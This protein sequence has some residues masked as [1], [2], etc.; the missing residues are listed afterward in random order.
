MIK[1]TEYSLGSIE[2]PIDNRD[3]HYSDKCELLSSEYFPET[4]DYRGQMN[5]VCNQGRLNTCVAFSASAMK[6]WQEKKDVETNNYMSSAFIYENRNNKTIDT[7]C[8]RD[9]LDILLKKGVCSDKL[10]PYSNINS[11]VI[12]KNVF[13]EASM[14][15]IKGYARIITQNELKT[16]LTNNG[17]CLIT[18]PCYNNEN[19]FWKQDDG[20]VLKGG[21]CVLIVGYNRYGYILRNSWGIY[22]GE[23]GHT[24]Y[25]YK[26]W[27]VHWEIW[28]SI[29]LPTDPNT[30]SPG[31]K[32]ENCCIFM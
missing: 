3:Y 9:A 28:S 27:G 4:I 32:E 26:D 23:L 31:I 13:D 8:C 24:Y 29:D 2:S 25:P 6:E 18:F 17:P 5:F 21:H 12:P 16:A 10:F 11:G 22:W 30:L 1:E 7:M 14:F 20:D 19:R 15:K